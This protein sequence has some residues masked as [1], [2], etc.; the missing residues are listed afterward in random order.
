MLVRQSSIE[1]HERRFVRNF[2]ELM[3]A[4]HF[5]LLCKE[6][7]EAASSEEFLVRCWCNAIASVPALAAACGLHQSLT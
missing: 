3:R 1:A 6:V 4:S 2:T 5:K 7:W